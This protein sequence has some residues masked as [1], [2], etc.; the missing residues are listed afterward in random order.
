MRRG[1]Y[2]RT[3]IIFTGGIPKWLFLFPIRWEGL[4]ADFVLLASGC[5]IYGRRSRGIGSCGGWWRILK[6]I[7]SCGIFLLPAEMRWW[8]RIRR[9]RIFW[10]RCTGWRHGSRKRILNG[11]KVRNMRSCNAYG[12]GRGCWLI[13]R[14]VSMTGWWNFCGSFRK[15]LRL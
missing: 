15:R 12:W 3:G 5:M 1:G 7:R 10:M 14:C 11:R 9:F 8:V 4:V 6:R 2:C 13:C